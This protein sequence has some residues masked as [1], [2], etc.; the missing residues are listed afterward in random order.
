MPPASLRPGCAGFP[1]DTLKKPREELQAS[2]ADVGAGPQVPW[3][4]GVRGLR[5]SVLGTLWVRREGV[6]LTCW[7]PVQRWGR[8]D[9]G[10]ILL[11]DN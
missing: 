2:R 8:Y 3:E 6:T 5:V 10:G 9:Y 7:G 4:L 11:F 1:E